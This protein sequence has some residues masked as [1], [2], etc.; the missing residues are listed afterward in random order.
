MRGGGNL[1]LLEV[2]RVLE[3]PEVLYLY[4]SGAADEHNFL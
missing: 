4:Q 1:V 2:M 3:L